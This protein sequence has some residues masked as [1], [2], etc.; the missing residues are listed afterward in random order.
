MGLE[1][2]TSK[3]QVI[4]CLDRWNA[5]DNGILDLLESLPSQTGNGLADS[6]CVL[7]AAPG[8]L[9]TYE[10]QW[11]SDVFGMYQSLV[12]GRMVPCSLLTKDFPEDKHN[13]NAYLVDALDWKERRSQLQG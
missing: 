12:E 6:P 13:D 9:V 11:G 5:G 2:G 8:S 1:P 3:Q 4:D 7:H 10:P